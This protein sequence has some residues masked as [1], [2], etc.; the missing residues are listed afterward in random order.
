MQIKTLK[1]YGKK[2][3]ESEENSE[4][5]SNEKEVQDLE[6]QL[7]HMKLRKFLKKLIKILNKDKQKKEILGEVTLLNSQEKEMNLEFILTKS[8]FFGKDCYLFVCF[9]RN[10]RN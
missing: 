10:E 8:K 9:N 1:V 7:A 3:A 4:K 6:N 2:N 5:L